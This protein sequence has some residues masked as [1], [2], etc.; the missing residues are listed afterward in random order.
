M[1]EPVYIPRHEVARLAGCCPRHVLRLVARGKL[2]AR[3][4]GMGWHRASVLAA[5]DGLAGVPSP[6]PLG[7][8][9]VA[10]VAAE[11]WDVEL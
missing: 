2:P 1:T 4:E 5:L 11:K 8:G 3:V 9:R 10:P 6:S 7:D